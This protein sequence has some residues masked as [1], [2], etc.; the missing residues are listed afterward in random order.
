MQLIL[1]NV[2]YLT[3]FI[4][5]IITLT[6]NQN[7]NINEIFTFFFGTKSYS[8]SLFALGDPRPHVAGGR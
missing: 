1:I 7:K 6:R 4:Q 3:Q 2:F 5:N 8:A